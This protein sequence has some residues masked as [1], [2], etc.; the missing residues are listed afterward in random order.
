MKKVLEKVLWRVATVLLAVLCVTIAG[1]FN[2]EEAYAKDAEGNYVVVIDPGHGGN[3]PGA[4]S[5]FTGD[6]EDE[7]NWSIATALKAE[8]ETYS[9]VKVYL[10]RGSAEYQSNTG[11]GSTAR[12]LGAD[13]SVGIHINS[14]EVESA[15]GVVCYGTVNSTYKAEI[16]SLSQKITSKISSLG[17]EKFNGGYVGR[18]S[19]YSNDIDFYTFIAESVSAGIPSLIIE[20][21]YVSNESDS[22]FVNKLENQQKLGIADATAIAQHLGLKKRGVKA[23]DCIELTRTYSAYMITTKQGTFTVSDSNVLHVREDGLITAINPGIATVTCTAADGTIETVKVLVPE[24]KP[25]RL[26]AGSM[27]SSFLSFDAA[28]SYDKSR[29]MVK[30]IYSDGTVKQISSGYTLGEPVEGTAVDEGNGHIKTPVN[31]PVSYENM[32]CTMNLYHY[33]KLGTSTGSSANNYQVVGTN[34]DVLVLPVAHAGIA[35]D[36]AIEAD[37]SIVIEDPQPE[38]QIADEEESKTGNEGSSISFNFDSEKIWA[39]V[40]CGVLVVVIIV[41][42]IMLGVMYNKRRRNGW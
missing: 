15:N 10:T 11:R 30:L 28:K 9:G 7:L 22:A 40:A 17:L 41:C 5:P 32:T 23:G 12:E 34:K 3:D 8:L 24:V 14:S 39:Y 6:T 29:V 35:D 27:Q 26:V 4:V 13:L 42:I 1:Q 33:T 31:V 37:A 36:T 18:V 21:C 19:T 16:K 20:H 38:T 25:V 2:I